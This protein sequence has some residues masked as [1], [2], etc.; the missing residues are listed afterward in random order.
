MY[1]KMVHMSHAA[2]NRT[3]HGGGLLLSGVA[4]GA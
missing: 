4:V 1:Q 2:E 3:A